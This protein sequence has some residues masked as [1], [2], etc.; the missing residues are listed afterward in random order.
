MYQAT[1]HIKTITP[2]FLSGSDPGKTEIR[3]SSFKGLMRFWWRAVKE[4]KDLK[5]LNENEAELFGKTDYGKSP[6]KIKID[7]HNTSIKESNNL[8]RAV[9]LD[10]CYDPKKRLLKGQDKG[11]AYLYFS[12][13]MQKRAFILPDSKFNLILSSSQQD[14]IKNAIASF[15]LLIH[16]G[17]VG[18]RSRRGGGNLLV[19]VSYTHLTL[20]TKA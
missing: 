3:A 13:M 8:K 6:I 18:A 10:S 17:G 15:W 1:F 9:S 2:L 7:S 11:I 12:M 19:A 20:P 4:H 5:D 14:V 16:L